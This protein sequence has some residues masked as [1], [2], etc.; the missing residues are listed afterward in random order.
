MVKQTTKY[1]CDLC[2][3][4]NPLCRKYM[5]PDF[6]YKKVYD[7]HNT[8]IRKVITHIVPIE[9]DICPH[10]AELIFYGIKKVKDMNINKNI[11]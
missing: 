4:E 6:S 3:K 8:S 2:D 9:A 7:K 11:I 1:Y 5:I 10:C